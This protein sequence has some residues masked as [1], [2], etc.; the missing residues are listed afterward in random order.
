MT[1]ASIFCEFKCP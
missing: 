1:R